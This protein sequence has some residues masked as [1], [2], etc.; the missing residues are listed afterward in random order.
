MNHGQGAAKFRRMLERFSLTGHVAIVTGAGRGIGAAIAVSYAKA[1]ADLVIAS[2]TSADVLRVADEIESIGRRVV[3]VAADLTL[4]GE[5]AGLVDRAIATWG[6]LDTVVNNLG[7]S[8]PRAFPDISRAQFETAL[9]FNLTSAFELSQAALP[10]LLE[11]PYGSIVNIASAAGIQ[12]NRGLASYGTAKAGLIALTRNMAQDLA[13]RVRVNAIAP[14][15][16]RTSALD[17]VASMPE[18]EQAMVDAIP[19]GRLGEPEDI[20]AAAVY[21]AS[22]AATFVTGAVLRVDGGA[23]GPILDLGFPDL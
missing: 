5:L 6:R 7:G 4:E 17:A 12:P 3:P 11:A 18:I 19:M 22:R 15:A 14:G 23:E 2:R 21:L 10:H 8:P 16:V 1:G 9:A 20:A 13:P